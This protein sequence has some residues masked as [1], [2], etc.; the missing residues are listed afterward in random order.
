MGAQWQKTP[1]WAAGGFDPLQ[2]EIN[3]I[4]GD[5]LLPS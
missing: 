5:E 1:R 2:P 3:E 4:K